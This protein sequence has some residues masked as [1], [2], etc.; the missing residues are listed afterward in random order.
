MTIAAA[1]PL[2]LALAV[3]QDDQGPPADA[4]FK[5]PEGWKALGESLWFDPATKALKIRARVVLREGFLEHLLCKTRTKEHES[6]LATPAA[7][8]LIHAGLLL[9][10]AEAGK[11]VQFVPEFKPP[12][13]TPIAI[14]LEWTEG[15][16]AREADARTWVR[17]EKTGK[18]LDVR[19]V[20][21]GSLL[22]ESPDGKESIYAADQGDLI[23]VANF[24]EAILDVPIASSAEDSA[25][26]FVADTPRLPPLNTWV[27]MT[28]KPAPPEKGK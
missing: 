17:E 10:G 21:A 11:A 27:T 24:P 4:A 14:T 19:W 9:T 28:L 26:G 16:E 22:V 12:A 20:F 3:A 1:L 18:P 23:T 25:R 7:P 5:A 2:L 8:R 6:I 13:G 15:G